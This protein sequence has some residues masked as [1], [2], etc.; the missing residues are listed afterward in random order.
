[1]DMEARKLPYL[2][3]NN[4]FSFESSA[5]IACALNTLLAPTIYPAEGPDNYTS[6]AHV[7]SFLGAFGRKL[8]PVSTAFPYPIN[9]KS[10]SLFKSLQENGV[11]SL[12]SIT[13]GVA[14]DCEKATG[15][16]FV[17]KGIPENGIITEKEGREIRGLQMK[18]AKSCLDQFVKERY[19][20]SVNLPRM[21][22]TG[23]K[24]TKPFP[25]WIVE[26]EA[27]EQFSTSKAYSRGIANCWSLSSLSAAHNTTNCENILNKLLDQCAK[28][29]SIGHK[30][31]QT[32]PSFNELQ[33]EEDDFL[34]AVN[35]LDTLST[36]Y[37]SKVSE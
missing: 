13:P 26:P 14:V 10:T 35:S 16:Y 7:S 23:L 28:R 2:N 34:D 18:D 5:V 3:Y 6:V 29:K 15:N 30:I 25:T 8:A 36:C 22:S 32:L 11:T 37:S 33:M 1:M 31:T 4:T 20:K 19:P 17:I 27:L 12:T 24:I 21:R 9:V